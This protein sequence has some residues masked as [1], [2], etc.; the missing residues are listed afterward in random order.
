MDTKRPRQRGLAQIAICACL[1]LW[2]C[3]GQPDRF[4]GRGRG[5]LWRPAGGVGQVPRLLR[6]RGRPGI[7]RVSS[8]VGGVIGTVVDTFRPNAGGSGTAAGQRIGARAGAAVGRFGGYFPCQGREVR[9]QYPS[10]DGLRPFRYPGP[11][12]RDRSGRGRFRRSAAMPVCRG[13]RGQGRFSSEPYRSGRGPTA[14]R[15][16][17]RRFD[18]DA[19]HARP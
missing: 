6:H 5:H 18:A 11:E 3:A 15:R 8:T 17:P 16:H 10:L 2:G 19:A 9:R 12:C 4:D 7:E 13:R 14:P 1:A